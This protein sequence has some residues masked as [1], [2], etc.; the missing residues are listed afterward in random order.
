L[1]TGSPARIN[2]AKTARSNS[3]DGIQVG[4]TG[5]RMVLLSHQQ[6]WVT[7][8]L[9]L[10]PGPAHIRWA[11]L[12]SDEELIRGF[13]PT[14]AAEHELGVRFRL[15]DLGVGPAQEMVSEYPGRSNA[16]LVA[17]ALAAAKVYITSNLGY[18]F[19]TTWHH[20]QT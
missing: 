10:E 1:F 5:V 3:Y 7:P 17:V 14:I 18:F 9:L 20:K 11:G 19:G 16:A 13:R 2:A 4:W 15:S 8:W 12:A 6:S